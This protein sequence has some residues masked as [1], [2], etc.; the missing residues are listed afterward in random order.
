MLLTGTTRKKSSPGCPEYF[1][2]RG[3]VTRFYSQLRLWELSTGLPKFWPKRSVVRVL[4]NK[5]KLKKVSFYYV[6]QTKLYR[7]L[8]KK[9]CG[10]RRDTILGENSLQ[11]PRKERNNKGRNLWWQS[12]LSSYQHQATT[13]AQDGRNLPV[14][15]GNRSSQFLQYVSVLAGW[16]QV[17]SVI[18]SIALHKRHQGPTW[19]LPGKN[20]RTNHNTCLWLKLSVLAKHHK[21]RAAAKGPNCACPTQYGP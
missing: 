1:Y 6:S 13:I 18:P 10:S 2:P 4:Q 14:P 7:L 17:Q 5:P 8:P 9:P 19:G 15:W 3:S 21:E 20:L 12:S 16:R 11:K